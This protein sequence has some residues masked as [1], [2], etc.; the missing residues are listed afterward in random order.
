M[1]QVPT[2]P[3]NKGA[4]GSLKLKREIKIKCKAPKHAMTSNR[5]CFLC[6]S[7]TLALNGSY[8]CSNTHVI[9]HH[10]QDMCLDHEACGQKH[11]G[12][13]SRVLIRCTSTTV[14]V[15]FWQH[16]LSWSSWLH[17]F[18]MIQ[19]HVSRCIMMSPVYSSLQLAIWFH[20][21]NGM[22]PAQSPNKTAPDHQ[23]MDPWNPRRSMRQ[24]SLA[25]API[26][27]GLAGHP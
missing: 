24:V 2:E 9:F 6:T 17:G 5:T 4:N 25:S 27:E 18:N 3:S 26:V 10:V 14:Q 23:G 20:L 19:F 13:S 1:Q 16:V 11:K 7:L 21:R 22:V 12:P 8:M 15:Q